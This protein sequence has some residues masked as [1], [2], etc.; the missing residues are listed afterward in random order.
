MCGICGVVYADPQREVARETIVRMRDVLEHRG[1]DD[2]GL[3]V[4]GPVGLGH[5]RLSIIDLS[6]RAHQPMASASGR[7]LL[8]YNGEIYNYQAIRDDLKALGHAFRSDSDT[9]VLVEGLDEWG[10]SGLLPRLDGIFAFAA[11]DRQERSLLAA[12]DPLG[13]KP[14][15]YQHSGAGIAFGSELRALWAG[16]AGR[17]VDPAALEELLVFRSVA[18]DATPFVGLRSLLPGHS[19]EFA[20]GRVTVRPYWCAVDH[21]DSVPSYEA[22]WK[23]RF[24]QAV[25]DQRVSDVPIGTL[26]SGG[27]D[28][29]T[30]TAEL[31][32]LGDEPLDTFT[33]SVPPE[34]GFDEWPYAEA[35]ATRWACRGH[36][37]RVAPGD[38]LERLREAQSSHCE[39]LAH[40][41]DLHIHELSR[42]AKE[43][44]SVLLSGEGADETLGGYVRYQPVLFPRALRAA[45]SPLGAPLR[46][47]LRL[48]RRRSLR[49][50]HRILGLR[51][52]E[53]VLLYNASDLLP[54]DLE[55]IG[56]RAS[57]RF[58]S[59]RSMLEQARKATPD[60]LKQ[61]M[62]YDIQT[63]LCSILHRNDRMTMAASIEC[64][65]PFLAVGVVEAALKLPTRALFS[66]REGKQV[67][68]DHAAGLL[69]P[70]VLKRAK[71]GLGIPWM[72][73]LRDDPACRDVVSKL[74]AGDVGHALDAPGF[75][76]AVREFLQG[77]DRWFPLVYQTFTLAVWWEQVVAGRL[78]PG[79]DSKGGRRWA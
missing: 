61:L 10:L 42:M 38:L 23:E 21:V 13:V 11:W 8:T 15:Y 34:E 33:V 2:A 4:E 26:L 18:G 37:L 45:H 70:Q 1:P 30:V 41:N 35:V 53:E 79:L 36:R 32:R 66:G 43:K 3:H 50:L 77:E 46:S 40:G 6:E 19:L 20:R 44:V 78:S 52:L 7:Y 74:P 54:S 25:R 47:L 69:P 16:G 59:R 31:A 72:R 49:S 67:L 73:Y 9:E 63:F 22:T 68:R 17:E 60:P 58:E 24:R 14:F 71:W 75:G 55:R 51:G 29:S 48:T 76:A 39:P 64:R 28:S 57:A 5:R 62:L 27:L 65:V 12:R 56:F